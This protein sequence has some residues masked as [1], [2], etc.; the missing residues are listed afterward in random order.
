MISDDKAGYKAEI[1]NILTGTTDKWFR[2]SDVKVAPDGSMIVADWYD[3]GV[4]GHGMGDLDRGRL[5]RILP[6]KHGGKYNVPK[7]DF[8][9][10]KGAIEALKNPNYAV[11]YLA[12]QALNKKGAAAKA[13]LQQLAKSKNPIYRARALWLLGRIEGNG[14]STVKQAVADPDPNL[15]IVGI[16]LAR[17]LK[18]GVVRM[19]D[20]ANDPSP[21]VRRE[22]AVALRHSTSPQ[23]AEVWAQLALKHDGKDRWYLEALGIGSDQNADACFAAWLDKVGNDW[24]TPAGHDIIWRSRADAAADYLVKILQQPKI[25]E[26]QQNRLMRAFDFHEG[27]RKDAALK[28]LLGL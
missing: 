14:P 20:L 26:A 6:G 11:R 4:G 19:S 12:W 15:R 18:L 9:S 17:Q 5:F 23:M 13:D 28:S 22:L 1:R 8:E 24:N 10:T 7:F 25:T 3:P 16:R 2:P 27:D 21:Q